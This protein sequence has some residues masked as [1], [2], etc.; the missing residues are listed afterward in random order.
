MKKKILIAEDNLAVNKA[1]QLILEPRYETIP[2]MDGKQAVEFAA[3][4]LPDL[5]LM[6]IIM[7]V[8]NGFQ[9]S[10]RIRQ[11]PK[12]RSIPIL[13]VTAMTTLKDKEECFQSGCDDYLSKPFTSEQL[14]S[15]IEKLLKQSSSNLSP[16]AP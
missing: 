8:M 6:D 16:L 9:A 1:L 3:T 5:I 14:L 11:H 4:Q 7:P 2:A 15:R 13:A 12:T 10:R